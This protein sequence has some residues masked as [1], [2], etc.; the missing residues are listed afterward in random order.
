MN[1]IERRK[2]SRERRNKLKKWQKQG[3]RKQVPEFTE[4]LNNM[5]T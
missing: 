1:D 3:N 5:L 2:R 4:M